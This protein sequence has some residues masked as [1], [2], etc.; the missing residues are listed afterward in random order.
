MPRGIPK[1]KDRVH[2][3]GSSIKNRRV[4]HDSITSSQH[5]LS[6]AKVIVDTKPPEL[7]T[8]P[9]V[10]AYQ[11]TSTGFSTDYDLDNS[12]VVE[13]EVGEDHGKVKVKGGRKRYL[14]SDAPLLTWSEK[15]RDQY[16]D[17]NLVT[18]GRGRLF[19]GNC[20][21]C[22]LPGASFRCLDCFGLRMVCKTCIL[23]RHRDEPLHMIQE[24]SS[25]YFKKT[26]LQA[27]GQRVQLGHPPYTHCN[28]PVSA[29]K[30]FVVLAWNG[31]HTITVDFCGCEDAIEQHLQVMEMGWWPSL[32]KEPRSAA[33]FNL[34]RNYHITNLQGHTP[35]SD[36]YESLEQFNDG[37]GLVKQPGRDAQFMLMLRQWRHIKTAKRIG[38]GHDPEGVAGTTL[39]SATVPC[40][41]CPHP[42][43]NLPVD[44]KSAP[45]D[46]RFL[47]ALFLSE[48]ANF[49]QKA[50]ARPNDYRD[51]ALGPGWGAFVPNG[52]YMEEVSK[53]ANEKEISHCVGF[54]AMSAMNTK[55]TKGL[56]ATGVGSVTCAR[57]E[58]F[59]PNGMGDLQVGERFVNMDFLALYTLLGTALCL[60]YF[61]YDIA[62]QWMKNFFKR[63]SDFPAGM[64]LPA[65]LLII[66]KVPKFHLPVHTDVC[67]AP[68]SF[69]Y[70]EGVGKTDGEAVERSWAWFNSCA[71]SVSMMTAGAR[72]DTMDDFTSYFNMRKMVGLQ[73]SLIKKMVKAIPE[74]VV[75]ARAYCAFNEALREDHEKDILEW[76]KQ[77]EDWETGRAKLCPYDVSECKLT[78]QQVKKDIAN[79]DHSREIS[80]QNS[81]GSTIGGLIIEGIEIEERQRAVQATVSRK[82]L[83]TNQET[84]LQKS[85]S[86]LLASIRKFQVKQLEHMPGIR[87]SVD[88]IPA[89]L[90]NEPEKMPLLLPNTLDSQLRAKVCSPELIAMEERVY[91]AQCFESLSKLRS[92]LRA[93]S[94]AYKNTSRVTQS[95]GMYTKLRTLR[96]QIEVKIK[97]ATD[98][99]RVA[100]QALLHLKGEGDWTRELRE[101]KPEDIRGI[102]KRLLRTEEKD[103]F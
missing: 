15:H 17:W 21:D 76:Q 69:N 3:T 92:Q 94:V 38:R 51:P 56:R 46:K 77:V 33:T 80:G 4:I 39:G 40:R 23:N 97:T 74:A 36:F 20:V 37:T 70:T 82:N 60:V 73:T 24:W 57:H 86:S 98:T 16:L 26:S 30:D 42:G 49:K 91:H 19:D 43:I 35:P 34:L 101:L 44:W 88:N 48:D 90:A 28:F 85:R 25:D 65:G 83:M 93:R 22:K 54:Q 67:L 50:R 75:N 8:T 72:W 100:R 45:A 99:Y 68:F 96:N 47:Y 1:P 84:E 62:C 58:C 87:H 10:G 79:E 95:Q 32:Y 6:T 13:E 52:L 11:E 61:S 71:R 55:R 7:D 9:S 2:I 102:T 66:F 5:R 78:I 18:E 81:L 64:H 59:R 27:L 41:S 31:I 14:D 89:E 103:E 12:E 63:M 29:H 53:R